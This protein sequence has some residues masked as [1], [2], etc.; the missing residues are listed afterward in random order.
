MMKRIVF[1]LFG[2]LLIL[3]TACSTSNPTSINPEVLVTVTPPP[4]PQTG[5]ATIT[6]RVMQ[7]QG[8]AM[9]DT[10][11]RLA[12]VARGAEGRGG[13]YI[14]DTAHSPGTR[15]DK[16]GFFLFENVKAGEYVI[17]IGDVED[18]GVYEIV[19]ETNGQAKVWNLPVDKVTDVGVLTVSFVNPTPNPTSAPGVYPGPVS[20][21]NP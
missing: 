21:P 17:V 4:P 6:G 15:T 2:L 14:L 1:P 9:A 12:D 20:Y 13:A 19:K 3:M 18:T 16:D 10:I 5:M 11:V 8:Y 7:T